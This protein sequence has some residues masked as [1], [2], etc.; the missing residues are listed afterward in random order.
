MGRSCRSEVWLPIGIPV[1]DQDRRQG[2]IS[3]SR[4]FQHHF[5]SSRL[6]H[7]K[8]GS[9]GACHTKK[10]ACGK[11]IESQQACCS[12]FAQNTLRGSTLTPEFRHRAP[13]TETGFSKEIFIKLR[14]VDQKSDGAMRQKRRRRRIEE[15]ASG[16]T[17]DLFGVLVPST[18]YPAPCSSHRRS[19]YS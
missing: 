8:R 11:Q 14:V 5:T 4:L 2:H 3:D 18:L 16:C 10:V 7:T 9:Q 1:A 12:F 13:H 15:S 19:S 17:D 6:Q